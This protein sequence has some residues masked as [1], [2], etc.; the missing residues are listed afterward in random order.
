MTFM[1]GHDGLVNEPT[2]DYDRSYDTPLDEQHRA[3]ARLQVENQALRIELNQALQ[4]M[5]AREVIEQAKGLLMAHYRCPA[6]A[7]F[8]VLRETSQRT[9]VKLRDLAV[10]LTE[11]ASRE[12]RVSHPGLDEAAALVLSGDVS[13]RAV[14]TARPHGVGPAGWR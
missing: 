8:A 7:A 4:A 9:N 14:G 10:A 1:A 11:L 3:V 13:E 2:P 6:E 5:A 12:G